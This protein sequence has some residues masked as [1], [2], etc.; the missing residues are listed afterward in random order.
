[1]LLRLSNPHFAGCQSFGLHLQIDFRID[2]RRVQ[3]GV[4]Q[5]SAYRVDVDSGAEKMRG[6]AVPTIPGP[7]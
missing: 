5:P 7:E 1:M 3:R 6:E 2:I 4:T